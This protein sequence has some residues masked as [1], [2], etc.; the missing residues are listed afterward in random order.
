MF[1]LSRL[2]HTFRVPPSLLSLPCEEV[3]KGELEKLFLDKVIAKLGLCV[4]VY[5]IR[6]IKGGFIFPSDGAPTYTVVFRLIMFRPFEGEIIAAKLKES[7]S[8]GL[9]LS[10]GFFD[11]IYIP[12][13]LFP[14]PS[15][16]KP[17]PN[18][19]DKGT[20]EWEFGGDPFIVDGIDEIL[21][22]VRSISY[23]SIPLEQP[24]Q[25]KPFAPMRITNAVT[26]MRYVCVCLCL[27]AYQN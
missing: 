26:T 17:D 4:S 21:F 25:A 3:V 5:D 2:E 11:D 9:R 8:T 18:K 12:V 13:E 10:L 6:S 16:F 1:Y 15:S 27:S 19:K 14:I 22:R 7:N 24:E 20:W 23:P